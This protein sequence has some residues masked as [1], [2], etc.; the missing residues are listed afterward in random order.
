MF[1]FQMLSSS[2]SEILSSLAEIVSFFRKRYPSGL[3]SKYDRIVFVLRENISLTNV[4]LI[5]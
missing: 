3:R 1:T 4:N 2:E 5:A